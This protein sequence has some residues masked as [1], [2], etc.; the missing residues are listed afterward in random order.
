MKKMQ[1]LEFERFFLFYHSFNLPNLSFAPLFFAWEGFAF[2]AL[3]KSEAAPAKQP[4]QKNA[5]G[6]GVKQ[7]LR[8]CVRVSA[9][10]CKAVQSG[11]KDIGAKQKN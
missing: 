5:E 3:Q 11:A 9:K 4:R 8:V 1:F 2:F 6:G 10:R 7:P